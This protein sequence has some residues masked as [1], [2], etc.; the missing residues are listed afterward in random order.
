MSGPEPGLGVDRCFCFA[1]TFASLRETADATGA[2][3]VAALQ[4]HALFG[5]NCRLCHPYVR[6]MLRTGETVFAHIVTAED[7]PEP[8]ASR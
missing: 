4:E 1:R 7:E 5:Q 2:A 6:R 3:T 8:Q